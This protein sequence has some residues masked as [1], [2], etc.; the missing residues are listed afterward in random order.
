MPLVKKLIRLGD[1]TPEFAHAKARQTR[2]SIGEPTPID[3]IDG[4]NV[5]GWRNWQ[6]L[7]DLKL[8]DRKRAITSE[9]DSSAFRSTGASSRFTIA[10]YR[11]DFG[12]SRASSH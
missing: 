3:A 10:H 5:A 11:S 8:A 2:K 7:R 12:F 9:G 6:T 4:W 1:S